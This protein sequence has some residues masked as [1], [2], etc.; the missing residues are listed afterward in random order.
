[1][2]KINVTVWNE[3]YHERESEEVRRVYPDG[4][5]GCIASFLKEDEEIGTVRA[6]TMYDEE[7]G[8]KEED[9]ADTDVLIY[10]A[11]CCHGSIEDK[12][13]QRI[14]DH[15]TN[16]G[17]GLILLHSAHASKIFTKLCGT[18]T[19]ALRWR[20]S[21]DKE[22]VWVMEPQHPICNNI[23]EYFELEHEETYGERFVIPA[24]D[25][26]VFMSWFSGGEIFRSG[27]CYN[28]GY[29]KIFYFRPGHETFPTYY[30]KTI[31]QVIK[32]AVKWAAPVNFPRMQTGWTPSLENP[33]K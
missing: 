11:H 2:K 24:P 9:L 32:N 16:R 8:F 13:V 27:V 19:G 17:M 33:Q 26:I 3:G 30:N 10:W 21:G 6:F 23:P 18:D 7:Q 5:Q 31:Q 22:R 12:Y 4:I 29:G 1:M 25:D 28:R 14:W 15:V 20:E